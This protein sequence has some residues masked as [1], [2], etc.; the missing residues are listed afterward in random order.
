MRKF[1][2]LDCIDFPE[3]KKL[4][5]IIFEDNRKILLADPRQKINK[6]KQV[7][8]NEYINKHHVIKLSHFSDYKILS[9]DD[10]LSFS[11][12]GT[13]K[14]KGLA[15]GSIFT[16]PYIDITNINLRKYWYIKLDS[17]HSIRINDDDTFEIST[18]FGGR[19]QCL[20]LTISTSI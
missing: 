11:L 8:T 17:T 10:N 2:E 6:K 12:A 5:G 18:S 13:R 7:Y 20:Q 19:D 14:F 15:V 1:I 4:I 3:K 9:D 16:S